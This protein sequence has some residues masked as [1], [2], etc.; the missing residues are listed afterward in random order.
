MS[1]ENKDKNKEVK[2]RNKILS[3]YSIYRSEFDKI[4]WPSRPELIRKTITVVIIS[5]FFGAYI[6]LLDGALATIYTTLVGFLA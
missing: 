6:A 5:G 3:T 1:S 4:V 2:G